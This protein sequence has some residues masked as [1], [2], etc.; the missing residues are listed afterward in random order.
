MSSS[1]PYIV[2]VQRMMF[3]F[4]DSS[5]GC[6]QTIEL[7]EQIARNH[8]L[9][10]ARLA[11]TYAL[12]RGSKLTQLDDLLVVIRRNQ[13][14]LRRVYDFLKW[15]GIRKKVRQSEPVEEVD[16]GIGLE[17][18]SA[19]MANPPPARR[20]RS[21]DIVSQM[22]G[23][24]EDCGV[25][26]VDMEEPDTQRLNARH[27]LTWNMSDDEYLQYTECRKASFTYKH[28]KRFRDW[29]DFAR[30]GIKA[31]DDVVVIDVLGYLAWEVVG[32][33]TLTAIVLKCCKE[34]TISRHILCLGPATGVWPEIECDALALNP[35]MRIVNEHTPTPLLPVHLYEAVRRLTT[36]QQVL[37]GSGLAPHLASLFY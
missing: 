18:S 22:H 14:Q 27:H 28:T 15:R 31:L 37:H 5:T 26:C 17:V 12:E 9:T 10:L 29:L 8:C 4:G 21:S 11:H 7:M 3:T 33:V 23:L 25:R 36:T 34:G 6:I 32:L 2:Q 24:C 30:L 19:M 16:L 1:H 35:E 20:S 13:A